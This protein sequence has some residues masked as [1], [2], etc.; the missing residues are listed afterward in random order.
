MSYTADSDGF[1]QTQSEWHDDHP[2]NEM[3]SEEYP[4]FNLDKLEKFL[5]EEEVF[6]SA[7]P[8]VRQ[9]AAVL[10]PLL[11]YVPLSVFQAGRHRKKVK[12]MA[13]LKKRIVA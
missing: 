12:N 3:N 13:V 6:L 9:L 4:P 10:C 1:I 11:L 8:D 2:L 5:N 7:P